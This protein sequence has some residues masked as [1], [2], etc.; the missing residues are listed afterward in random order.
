V[1]AKLDFYIALYDVKTDLISFP[2]LYEGGKLTSE[3]PMKMGEGLTSVV[4]Q[5]QEP[6]LLSTNASQK[7]AAMGIKI[8]GVPARSWLGVPLIIGGQVMGAMVAEDAEVEGRLT[9]SE[10]KLFTTLAPQV[11][12]AIRNAQLLSEMQSAL[13]DY[14]QER[15]LLNTLLENIPDVVYF[16][17]ENGRYLRTSSSFAQKHGLASSVDMLGKSDVEL[18]PGDP[19]AEAIHNE[20]MEIINNRSPRTGE[21]F[22]VPGMDGS[23]NWASTSRLPMISKDD[24]AA[25]LLGIAHDIT[26]LKQTEQLA[27][28][29]AQQLRTMAEIARDTSGMLDVAGLL[30]KSVNLIRDRFGFYHASIF[31]VD[32][33]NQYAVLRESTGEA[34][35]N[36]KSAGHR[37]A[38]GSSSIVGQA[39]GMGE[40]QVENDV[41]QTPNYY[42]NPLLPLTRSEMALPLK[43]GERIVGALDVQSMEVNAFGEDD[44][45]ILGILADQLAVAIVN[46]DL[47]SETE[48][49]IAKHRFLHQITTGA[50]SATTQDEALMTTVQGL[51]TALGSDRVAVYMLTKDGTLEIRASAGYDQMD[52][53]QVK[54]SQ[55]EGAVGLAFLGRHPVLVKDTQ[56][57]NRFAPLDEEVR[58]QLAVPILYTDRAIGALCIGSM[59]P[60]AYDENDQEILGSLGSTLGAIIAN[61]QLMSQVRQQVEQQ[62]QIYEITSK[63]RKSSEIETILQTSARELATV[64]KA[65]RANIRIKA[66]EEPAEAVHSNGSNGRKEMER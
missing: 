23:T 28:K 51:K 11:A 37:L 2:Y 9:E 66:G 49:N 41:T 26:D 65:Q 21:I 62:R 59:Q 40:T 7:T 58:S 13:H 63:I 61:T 25:G 14:D 16:K 44:V 53:S 33:L 45:K 39:T 60:A 8:L 56:V 15:F 17:D 27:Q 18:M 6:L 31:L 1:A 24:Q 47:F 32:A 19:R 46:A 38:V 50:A 55:G 42:P 52:L 12:V 29:R 34:G 30:E 35:S 5:K 54:I 36:M 10:L 57:D 64:F 4:L 48:E 22:A 3:S 43:V 20:E